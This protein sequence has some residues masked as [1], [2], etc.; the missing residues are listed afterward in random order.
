MR[1][2]TWKPVRVHAA[3]RTITWRCTI[4]RPYE[5]WHMYTGES[6][7]RVHWMVLWSSQVH[8]LQSHTLK[9]TTGYLTFQIKNQKQ[10]D[11]V[12]G[13]SPRSGFNLSALTDPVSD[14]LLVHK[15]VLW[16]KGILSQVS[17]MEKFGRKKN[18]VIK[19]SHFDVTC[20]WKVLKDL[21]DSALFSSLHWPFTHQKIFYFCNCYS[22]II[23]I[24]WGC[25]PSV[26]TARRC[27]LWWDGLGGRRAPYIP[28][29][30][31]WPKNKELTQVY[32]S[33]FPL[34]NHSL[35]FK[36]ME[37]PL[38]LEFTQEGSLKDFVEDNISYFHVPR[39]KPC[40]PRLNEVGDEATGRQSQYIFDT[41]PE[42]AQLQEGGKHFDIKSTWS[43]RL[44]AD[45]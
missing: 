14:G 29:A 34:G 45:G 1:E 17:K 22:L 35:C 36:R 13:T 43:R 26:F 9:C 12:P 11:I 37:Q 3:A 38:V 44:Q 25:S 10:K 4:S 2:V 6:N 30:H 5:K 28:T 7:F 8:V 33:G 31:Y 40:A 23:K 15:S 27:C 24:A 32:F 19:K 39:K 41:V 18:H 21:W 20:T 42:V 16:L